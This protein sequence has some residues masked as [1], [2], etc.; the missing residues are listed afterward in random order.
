[1]KRIYYLI[2]GFI[3][4]II[5]SCGSPLDEGIEKAELL[6]FEVTSLHLWDSTLNVS[7]VELVKVLDEVNDAIAELGYP[8][9]GYL[10]WKVQNDT[11]MQNRYMMLGSWPDKV[12]YDSIHKSEAWQSVWEKH[13]EFLESMKEQSVYSRYELVK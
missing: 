11:L 7:E 3:S 10:L 8:G 13:S 1:M 12:A 6:Q 4:F 2:F 5:V 9:A